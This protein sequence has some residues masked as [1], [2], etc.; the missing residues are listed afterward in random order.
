MSH[1]E[2]AQNRAIALNLEIDQEADAHQLDE[3]GMFLTHI[4]SLLL[5]NEQQEVINNIHTL[6]KKT[7]NRDMV[8]IVLGPQID[9]GPSDGH[10]KFDT[11]ARLSFG[12]TL[13]RQRKKAALHSYRFH[14]AFPD[15]HSPAFIRFDL[16][17]K[18]DRAHLEES[19]C[20][21]HPGLSKT[22]IPSR[23]LSPIEV[24]DR[25]FYVLDKC[26]CTLHR[27]GDL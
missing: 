16:S 22:R 24:L 23:V 6:L 20:H 9:K 1:L 8:Y 11:G 12:I 13:R 26:K 4:R 21:I 2:D 17:P 19:R 14:Y 18:G 27:D 7:E 5:S 15:G 3:P 10:F 25:V